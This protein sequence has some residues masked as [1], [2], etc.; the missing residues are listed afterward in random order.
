MNDGTEAGDVNRGGALP[1]V[2]IIGPPA[3]GK[4][5]VGQELARLTGYK[6][7]YNHMI[8]DLITEFFPY[9]SESFGRLAHD[10]RVRIIT[11]FAGAGCGAVVTW[12]WLRN[13]AL[14]VH[15]LDELAA[16][17]ARH[18]ADTWFA[19]L[20]ASVETRVARNAT[21]NRH[22]HKKKLDWATEEYI[23]ARD[24]EATAI[25]HTPFAYPERYLLIDNTDVSAA[26]AAAMIRAHFGL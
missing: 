24:D 3:V 5:T 23:R 21:E 26:V 6:L 22:A 12:G 11:E 15:S 16:I 1:L 8:I 19:E 14:D 4:M 2:V 10:L 17:Y 18:G 9:D 7:L 13:L 20:T 25:A